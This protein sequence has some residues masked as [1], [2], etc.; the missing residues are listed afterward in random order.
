VE[1]YNIYKGEIMVRVLKV[2]RRKQKM[3][4]RLL[5]LKAGITIPTLWALETRPLKNPRTSTLLKI[6]KALG[7][8]PCF[9]LMDDKN[10]SPQE[11]KEIGL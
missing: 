4:Q 8:N 6:G 2:I 1:L 3:T 11:R 5:C 10:L 9:L 7:V